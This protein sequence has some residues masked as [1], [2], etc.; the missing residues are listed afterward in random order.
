MIVLVEL[1]DLA[2][3]S[4]NCDQAGGECQIRST[5]AARRARGERRHLTRKGRCLLQD[6]R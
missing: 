2:F 6:H 3:T 5:R 1:L 4:R